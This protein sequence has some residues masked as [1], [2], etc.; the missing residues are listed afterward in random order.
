MVNASFCVL[1][2]NITSCSNTK[3]LPQLHTELFLTPSQITHNNDSFS[4]LNWWGDR[5]LYFDSQSIKFIH[6]N[7]VVE[8][9]ILLTI[10]ENYFQTSYIFF[11]VSPEWQQNKQTSWNIWTMETKTFSS[12]VK[13]KQQDSQGEYMEG[14]ILFCFLLLCYQTAL[15]TQH[16]KWSNFWTG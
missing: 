14:S 7:R 9:S 12:K 3:E 15:W 8:I 11:P 5:Q 1:I 10:S 6:Q 16:D 2:Q 4:L 13:I